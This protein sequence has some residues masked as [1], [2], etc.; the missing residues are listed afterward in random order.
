MS[1]RPRACWLHVDAAYAGAVALL[2]ERRAPFAGWERADSIVVNPHKWLFTP[3]DAS[4]LLTRRMDVAAVGV[5]PG[6]RNTCARS[7]GTTPV[8]DFNELHPAAGTP[9]PG[10]QALD[11]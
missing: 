11:A 5:Q 2:P 3:L 10:A 9:V 6:A 7:T 8:R 1:R 4:L